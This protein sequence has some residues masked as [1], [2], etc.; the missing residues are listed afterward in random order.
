MPTKKL[1][2]E[3]FLLIAFRKTLATAFID[4]KNQKE[5]TK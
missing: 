4:T 3:V 5:V 1:L 2:S